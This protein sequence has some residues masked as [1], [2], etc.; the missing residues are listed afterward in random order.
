MQPR[1]VVFTEVLCV[2]DLKNITMDVSLSLCGTYFFYFLF[3]KHYWVLLGSL[4][5]IKLVQHFFN[6]KIRNH[7]DVHTTNSVQQFFEQNCIYKNSIDFG[8]SNLE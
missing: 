4:Y 1:T 5:A 8:F 2:S 3:N 7:V 6:V